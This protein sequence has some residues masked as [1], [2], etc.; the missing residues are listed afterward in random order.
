MIN[1]VPSNEDQDLDSTNAL[2]SGSVNIKRVRS[3]EH[4]TDLSYNPFPSNGGET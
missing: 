1:G 3:Q 4:Y 2:S